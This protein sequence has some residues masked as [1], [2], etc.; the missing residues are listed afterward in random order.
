MTSDMPGSI[1][2]RTRRFNDLAGKR[3]RAAGAGL[4]NRK[5]PPMLATPSVWWSP[6]RPRTSPNSSKLWFT[7]TFSEPSTTPATPQSRGLPR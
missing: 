7:R 3:R 6:K 5:T 4:E 1:G 2:G